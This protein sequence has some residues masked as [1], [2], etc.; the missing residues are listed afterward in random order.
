MERSFKP[1]RNLIFD[2]HANLNLENFLR[3]LKIYLK[4]AGL[5]KKDDERKIAILL[6]HIGE[7]ARKKF[8]TFK[9]TEQEAK[10]YTNVVQAFK[11]Y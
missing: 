5:D 11:D 6:N 4:T 10:T 9:L 2:R 8:L 1:P 7:E 3:R